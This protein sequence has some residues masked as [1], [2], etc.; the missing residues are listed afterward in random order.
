MYSQHNKRLN[1]SLISLTVTG[2]RKEGRWENIYVYVACVNG[3]VRSLSTFQ[4]NAVIQLWPYKELSRHLHIQVAH[5]TPEWHLCVRAWISK[6]YVSLL[7]DQ[8]MSETWFILKG[9]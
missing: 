2:P 7:A 8:E 6:F 3:H 5:S 9:V 4:Q 1:T